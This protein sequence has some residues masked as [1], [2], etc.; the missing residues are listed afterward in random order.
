M[1][2]VAYHKTLAFTDIIIVSN[3][4]DDGSLGLLDA[5]GAAGEL[6]HILQTVPPDTAP[7]KNAE[8]VAREAGL[9]RDGDWVLWLDLDEFLLPS[10]PHETIG[11]LIQSLGDAEAVMIA[12][13]FFG[14]SG[15][16]DWPGRHVSE[17][18]QMAAPRTKGANAQ[19]KTL[20]RYGPAIE[21][22]DIH[23]PVLKP[24]TTRDAFPAITSSRWP[25]D[26]KFY[27]TTRDRPF[28]R[29]VA[30]KRPYILGQIAHFS[31]RTPSLFARKAERGDGYYADPQAVARDDAVYRRRNFNTVQEL[32]LAARKPATDRELERLYHLPGV[33]EA[34][35]K[36]R[37]FRI[38]T[39]SGR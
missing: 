2:W 16:Q 24:G 36:I 33:A 35:G 37:D 17:A 7:Q 20:F 6:T 29:L 11:D 30:Q 3:D 28:N 8:R 23:R 22:L 26:D 9:F 27:D 19:V 39:D 31:I 13:R 15:N 34:C 25:V 1:E 14:D 21:R 5:L 12:W 10:P 4:C 32:G 38:D 18:F